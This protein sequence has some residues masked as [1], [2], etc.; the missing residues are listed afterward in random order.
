MRIT[1]PDRVFEPSDFLDF[2][3]A[4]KCPF[5]A[6][7]S[8]LI[9][10][11]EDGSLAVEI[12]SVLRQDGKEIGAFLKRDVERDLARDLRTFYLNE[13]RRGLEGDSAADIGA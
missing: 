5:L 9:T 2:E 10:P 12:V 3:G 8:A 13:A 11:E 6:D 4:L 7:V 1:W